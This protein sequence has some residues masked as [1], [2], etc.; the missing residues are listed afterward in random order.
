MRQ[1]VKGVLLYELD[2]PGLSAGLPRP[3]WLCRN[4]LNN[5]KA[6]WLLFSQRLI[7]FPLSGVS[8]LWV[9]KPLKLSTASAIQDFFMKS[10]PKLWDTLT[11]QGNWERLKDF[12]IIQFLS[13]DRSSSEV[14][15]PTPVPRVSSLS[16]CWVFFLYCG[17]RGWERR[18]W[19]QLLSVWVST[20]WGLNLIIHLHDWLKWPGNNPTIFNSDSSS[21]VSGKSGS[22][23][24]KPQTQATNLS[25]L[26]LF[27]IYP[28]NRGKIVLVSQPKKN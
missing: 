1:R 9:W 2:F 17:E 14:R 7:A 28:R 25:N 5:P 20:S 13:F 26:W 4:T 15:T 16:M 21:D 24:Y 6:K 27:F 19:A 8:S 10:S 12:I 18:S 11:E 22:S 3:T 23:L